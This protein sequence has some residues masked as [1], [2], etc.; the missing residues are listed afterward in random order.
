[1]KTVLTRRNIGERDD[2]LCVMCDARADEMV[3][4]LFFTCS[5]ARACWNKINL[6]WDPNLDISDRILKSIENGLAFYPE[7]ILIAAWELWKARNDHIFQRHPPTE[8]RWFCNFR[9]QCYLQAAR[10]STDLRASFCFWLDA[11]S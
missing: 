10:F 2:D 3:E 4:H 11:F 7:A 5:F 6:N 1:M 9:N 8:D